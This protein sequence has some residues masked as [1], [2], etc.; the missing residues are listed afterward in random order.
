MIHGLEREISKNRN[1]TFGQDDMDLC[2]NHYQYGSIEYLYGIKQGRGGG[3]NKRK[4]LNPSG[5]VPTN[6]KKFDTYLR[7][8][9]QDIIDNCKL[10]SPKT[11]CFKLCTAQSVSITS[12]STK[13]PLFK[14]LATSIEF[15]S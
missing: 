2:V 15:G 12:T 1:I 13:T 8:N 10:I 14:N 4:Y 11:E 5:I 7:D 9:S 3:V 6:L